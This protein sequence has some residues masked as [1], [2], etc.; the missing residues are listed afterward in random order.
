M[1]LYPAFQLQQR[2]RLRTGGYRFWQGLEDTRDSPTLLNFV[3][4]V[5]RRSVCNTSFDMKRARQEFR[6]KNH[7]TG[8]EQQARKAGKPVKIPKDGV[9]RRMTGLAT[10]KI[11]ALRKKHKNRNGKIH[12][13]A[14]DS[15]EHKK[16]G[17]LKRLSV[18]VM[19]TVPGSSERKR[20][21]EKKKA[22]DQDG[23][24]LVGRDTFTA[25]K[26]K[27]DDN[28]NG[29]LGVLRLSAK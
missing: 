1:I 25:Y 6:E 18:A 9:A 10:D 12:P 20:R 27:A 16:P 2:L 14:G 22:S 21:K 3:S 19:A 29:P 11:D 24:S 7:I 5:K 28:T 23:G 4:G 17:R 8:P 15:K 26:A 13:A